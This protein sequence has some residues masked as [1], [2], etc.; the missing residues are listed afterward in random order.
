MRGLFFSAMETVDL[1]TPAFS[2]MSR[3]VIRLELLGFMASDLGV[4]GWGAGGAGARG[5]GSESTRDACDGRD[6]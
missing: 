6:F 3:S 2:A 1:E 4:V 5:C